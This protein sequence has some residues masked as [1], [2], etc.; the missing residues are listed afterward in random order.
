MVGKTNITGKKK[1]ATGCSSRQLEHVDWARRRQRLYFVGANRHR[2]PMSVPATTSRSKGA[3]PLLLTSAPNVVKRTASRFGHF[4]SEKDPGT[5]W[6]GGRRGSTRNRREEPSGNR[7][8][9][10]TGRTN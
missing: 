9:D 5:Y 2:E 3:N 6:T 8:P 1:Q 7:T 10:V 4:I